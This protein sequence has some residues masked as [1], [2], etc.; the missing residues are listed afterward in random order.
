MRAVAARR[1]GA[2]A[3]GE[4]REPGQS[5]RVRGFALP[6]HGS[7]MGGEGEAG[8]RSDEPCSC[9]L[10]SVRRA[11]A[12]RERAAQDAGARAPTTAMTRPAR[13]NPIISGSENPEMTDL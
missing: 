7:V 10:Y 9:C 5:E 2:S 6:A 3:R 1:A 12:V 4:G 13:A 8:C 11:A